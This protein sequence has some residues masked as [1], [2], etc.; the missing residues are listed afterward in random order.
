MILYR[1]YTWSAKT[2]PIRNRRIRRKKVVPD[3][4]CLNFKPTDYRITFVLQESK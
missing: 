2:N 4:T 1:I 3:G